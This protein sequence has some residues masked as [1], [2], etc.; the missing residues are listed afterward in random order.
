MRCCIKCFETKHIINLISEQGT[1]DNCDFCGAKEI[2]T[3]EA[4]EL[5]DAFDQLLSLYEPAERGSHYIVDPENEFQYDGS[6]LAEC[7]ADDWT[8]FNDVID[9]TK[10]NGLL[11]EIRF[12]DSRPEDQLVEIPSGDWWASK[13]DNYFHDRDEDV[14][15]NF[16]FHIKRKRRFLPKPDESEFFSEPVKWLPDLL[17]EIVMDIALNRVFFRARV[18][19]SKAGLSGPQPLPFQDMS[20][21]PPHNA[22]GGRANPAGIAYLYV[23]DHE[24]TAISEIRPFVGAKVTV[25]ILR[26]NKKLRIVDL[27]KEHYIETPFGHENLETLLMRNALLNALNKEL[28]RPVNPDDSEVEYVPT[29][30]LA[31]VVLNSGYDGIRYK[32]SVSASGTNLVF[33]SPADFTI[34]PVTKLVTVKSMQIEYQELITHTLTE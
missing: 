15:K 23:A 6:S 3:L 20:A 26:P 1:K 8:I 10:Q 32:S 19:F 16:A 34:D 22:P 12:G 25:A 30:Y 18:G 14:W 24:E 4:V 21:P 27:T 33:F 17:E 11:D 2:Q 7:I 29:Q 9:T 5:R 13:K 28:S 31:E